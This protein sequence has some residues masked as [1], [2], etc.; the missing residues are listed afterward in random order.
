MNKNDVK[1]YELT[2]FP[3]IYKNTYWGRFTDDCDK[4]IIENRDNF[5]INYDVKACV[6]MP[7]YIERVI[8]DEKQILG[9][10]FYDHL[11]FYKTNHNEYI[12]ICSP[13][14]DWDDKF[15]SFGWTR[16]NQIYSPSASTYMRTF[17]MKNKNKK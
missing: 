3:K 6:K 8:D 10:Y 14:G 17:Q 11:E 4:S 13:Y 15:H 7:Q 9:S 12:L 16:I 2:N 5:I 1:F